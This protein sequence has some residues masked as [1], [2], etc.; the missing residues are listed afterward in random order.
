MLH[1][2]ISSQRNDEPARHPR[3]SPSTH[4]S[5]PSKIN[6]LTEFFKAVA[7]VLV[8][9]TGLLSMMCPCWLLVRCVKN[10]GSLKVRDLLLSIDSHLIRRPFRRVGSIQNLSSNI[11]VAE[12]LPK[13]SRCRLNSLINNVPSRPDG[14]ARSLGQSRDRDLYGFVTVFCL[15]VCSFFLL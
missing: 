15:F 3:S 1:E 14:G 5:P 10:G 12:R 8:A 4:T 13:V 11:V 9:L 7:A 6:E 2:L